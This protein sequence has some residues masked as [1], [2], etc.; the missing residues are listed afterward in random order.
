MVTLSNVCH[1]NLTVMG[2]AGVPAQLHFSCLQSK[3]LTHLQ[4]NFQPEFV[5]ATG[6]PACGSKLASI[7]LS[8]LDTPAWLALAGMP[9]VNKVRR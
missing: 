9:S 1:L 4:L 8:A 7:H 3:H 2:A 5:I 6:A